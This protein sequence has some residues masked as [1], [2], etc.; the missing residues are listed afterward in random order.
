[1]VVEECKVRFRVVSIVT[2]STDPRVSPRFMLI[3][4]FLTVLTHEINEISRKVNALDKIAS[5]VTTP[6]HHF[7][8]PLVAAH[9]NG[10][11]YDVFIPICD[12][13]FRRRIEE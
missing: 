7:V 4:P 11:A 6:L 1:M 5:L 10:H 3:L 8:N 12:V 2:P 9:V 13:I